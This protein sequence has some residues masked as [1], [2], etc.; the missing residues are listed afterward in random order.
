MP[1]APRQLDERIR[2]ELDKIDIREV[3][4]RWN[5]GLD[6]GDAEM[7]ASTYLPDVVDGH[8]KFSYTNAAAAA[9]DYVARHLRA[10]R[11]HMHTTVQ[12]N[13]R[14]DG[15][16]AYCESYAIA[17][18]VAER[19]AFLDVRPP[20]ESMDE[21]LITVGIRYL[22]HFVRWHEEWRISER[23]AITEWRSAS[24]SVPLGF[25]VPGNNI[26]FYRLDYRGKRSKDDPSYDMATA[27]RRTGADR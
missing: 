5:L 7:L 13:I 1:N 17:Y 16:E 14:L 10:A 23:E 15:D 11:R 20:D 4:V 21:L 27:L 12:D 26:G 9:A 3:L 2:R 19:V 24:D 25:E 8:G 18:V 22:D 6:R